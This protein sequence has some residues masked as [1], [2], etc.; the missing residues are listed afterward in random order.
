MM[1]AQTAVQAAAEPAFYSVVVIIASAAIGL[2]Q[3]VGW[4]KITQLNGK[5]ESLSAV[6]AGI[7]NAVKVQVSEA[8]EKLWH[9]HSG[10]DSRVTGIERVCEERHGYRPQGPVSPPHGVPMY[11]ERSG[12]GEE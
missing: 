5:I 9:A 7:P 3:W 2:T 11:R 10:L 6:V 8:M 12:I 1:L 4:W